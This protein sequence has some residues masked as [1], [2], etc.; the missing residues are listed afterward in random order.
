MKFLIL[1]LIL[2]SQIMGSEYET[3]EWVGLFQILL[4][5]LFL[6]GLPVIITIIIVSCVSIIK[7]LSKWSAGM[8]KDICSDD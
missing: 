4:P 1:L 8:V 5:F 7:F 3:N 6:V 2:V